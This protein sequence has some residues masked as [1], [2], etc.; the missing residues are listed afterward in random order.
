VS[1]TFLIDVWFFILSL[2]A[3]VYAV[4]NVDLE[5]WTEALDNSAK[6]EAALQRC[7]SILAAA[8]NLKDECANLARRGSRSGSNSDRNSGVSHCLKIVE[9]AVIEWLLDRDGIGDGPTCRSL[10]ADC[11]PEPFRLNFIDDPTRR[12]NW[13]FRLN[14]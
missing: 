6:T 2:F 5:R 14:C 8:E 9:E 13:A 1:I 3:L 10:V 11:E 4:S 7:G 12:F